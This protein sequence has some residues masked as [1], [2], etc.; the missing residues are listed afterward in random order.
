MLLIV[1]AV[2]GWDGHVE[3]AALPQRDVNDILDIGRSRGLSQEQVSRM[4]AHAQRAADRGLPPE[5]ILNKI[6]EGLAKGVPPGRIDSVLN[7]IVG[8]LETA[9]EVLKEVAGRAGKKQTPDTRALEVTAEA[10]ARGVTPDEIRALSRSG[11]GKGGS[12]TPD[13]LAFGAKGLA[14]TKEAGL[15][16]DQGLPLISEALRQ[17][18]RPKDLLE[19]GRGVKRHG[20]EFR[21]DRSR[22][23][24]LKKALKRGERIDRLFRRDRE[25]RSGKDRVRAKGDERERRDERV[26]TDRDKRDRSG[27][28]DERGDRRERLQRQDRI[29]RS[30]REDRREFRS[31]R[32]D[33]SGRGRGRGGRDH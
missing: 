23:E 11:R 18:Y 4:L 10:L 1:G 24:E 32:G 25:S 3:S 21:Q 6:K 17:G 22:V 15:P 28:R 12:L 26:R 20:R 13:E 27:K 5:M 2:C 30:G 14:L 8:K 33:R 19:L 29:E 7:D 31:E 9:R 16:G